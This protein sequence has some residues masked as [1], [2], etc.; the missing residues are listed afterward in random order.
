MGDLEDLGTRFFEY[1]L[2]L[3]EKESRTTF[4]GG[5]KACVPDP[6]IIMLMLIRLF[7]EPLDFCVSLRPK[8][9]ATMYRKHPCFRLVFV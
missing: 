6:T 3:Y 8:L 1:I 5:R 7:Q 4:L 2:D 9:R